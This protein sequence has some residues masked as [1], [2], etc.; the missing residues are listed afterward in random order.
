MPVLPQCHLLVAFC[1]LFGLSYLDKQPP[2][3]LAPL[4]LV[5]RKQLKRMRLCAFP[6][7][8]DVRVLSLAFVGSFPHVLRSGVILVLLVHSVIQISLLVV[9][10]GV[11]V[12][13]VVFKIVLASRGVKYRRLTRASEGLHQVSWCD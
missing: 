5:V 8:L 1:A 11:A 9:E 2:P 12:Q 4:R 10:Q 3:E 6:E 13:V 7:L